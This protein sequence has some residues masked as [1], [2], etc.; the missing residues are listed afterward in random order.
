M[1]IYLA[2]AEFE[3]GNRIIDKAYRSYE[4][5][6]NAATEMI[7]DIEANT[8]WKVSPIIEDIDLED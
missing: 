6:K 8:D 5:A 3:D 1:K 4:Q 2:M 7:K